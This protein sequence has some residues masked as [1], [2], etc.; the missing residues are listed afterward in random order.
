MYPAA[1]TYSSQNR[2]RGSGWLCRASVIVGIFLAF[3]FPLCL[4]SGCAPQGGDDGPGPD[5]GATGPG[6]V[7]G[8]VLDGLSP[9]D[10]VAGADLYVYMPVHTEGVG[11]RQEDLGGPV[12]QA[13]SGE[14]GSFS[15]PDIPAGDCVLRVRPPST[16]RMG[17][18]RLAVDVAPEETQDV[19]V[20]MLPLALLE[21]IR[22][23]RITPTEAVDL[24]A[25]DTQQ[26]AAYAFDEADE[27]V[28]DDGSDL[29]RATWS[30]TSAIGA[31]DGEGRFTAGSEGGVG[32][33]RATF[34][35]RSE[36]ALVRVTGSGDGGPDGG[37]N[38]A[39]SITSV[40]LSPY[41]TVAPGSSCFVDVLADDPD[42]DVLTYEF[43]AD[44][45]VLYPTYFDGM[46]EWV[47]PGGTSASGARQ[48]T[49]V[50]YTIT[51]SVSDGA[52]SDTETV[53]VYVSDDASNSP[54]VIED[55][56]AT[57]LTAEPGDLVEFSCVASDIDG[58]PLGFIWEA[59]ANE[60]RADPDY[61]QYASWYAP[62]AEGAY[63]VRCTV[64]D[65]R[66]GEDQLQGDIEVST[67]AGEDAGG[68]VGVVVEGSRA[69]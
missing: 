49:G 59:E 6:T 44:G 64:R 39:P 37:D 2:A 50:P 54:P 42:G 56:Y 58:D 32:L 68:G 34:G 18:I 24:S 48:S 13:V 41:D 33:V 22:T 65:G 15:L 1:C 63:W 30:C 61:P 66:G 12:A 69:R 36:S 51:C 25:G 7:A 46:A 19:T 16:A 67:S 27:P 43:E 10:A 14:D 38:R 55:V 40:Q 57:Q 47:A 26:F 20:N 11:T 31:I 45:G 28:L 8:R 53:T 62:G 29:I 9:T 3:L 23:V 17:V 5:D 60:I 52:A 4:C 35:E 21:R